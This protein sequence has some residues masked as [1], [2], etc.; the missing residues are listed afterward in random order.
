MLPKDWNNFKERMKMLIPD[1]DVN[2][3]TENDFT[4][5]NWLY[6]FRMELQIWA[7][8]R[9]QLLARTVT[10]MMRN[11]KALQLMAKL[12]HPIPHTMSALEHERWIK[13][14]VRGS[15]WCGCSN[16][17]NRSGRWCMHRKGAEAAATTIY[18]AAC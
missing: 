9:G 3:L 10:G 2:S 7:S 1:I 16:K 12:E 11:V 13:K 17:I 14:M 8:C 6:D 18:E 4:Q 15:E 5:G